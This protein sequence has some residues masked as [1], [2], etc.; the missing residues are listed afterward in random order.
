MLICQVAESNSEGT[1]GSNYENVANSSSSEYKIANDM[2]EIM[3][4]NQFDIHGDYPH[5]DLVI[6]YKNI[7][8]NTPNFENNVLRQKS[9]QRVETVV[10]NDDLDTDDSEISEIN[11]A[12]DL[13]NVFMANKERIDLLNNTALDTRLCHKHSDIEIQ[14]S[15]VSPTDRQFAFRDPFIK[16]QLKNFSLNCEATESSILPATLLDYICCKRLEDN[17]NFYMDNIIRYVQHTIEQ[18]KRI[19]N[20]DYLTDRAKEKWRNVDDTSKNDENN[21]MKVLATSTSIPLRVERKACGSMSSWDD[22]VHSEVDVR[23]LSKILEKKIVVEIPKIICGS[24][25]IISKTCANN[26]FISCN[27]QSQFLEEEDSRVDV[28]LK[29]ERS[30]SGQV[31]SNINSI[32]LLQIPKFPETL[33]LTYNK[34]DTLEYKSHH[35][36]PKVVEVDQVLNTDCENIENSR[37]TIESSDIENEDLSNDTRYSK[38]TNDMSDS[39]SI[40]SSVTQSISDVSYNKPST[41]TKSS[42]S[43]LIPKELMISMRN[44]D[45]QSLAE[46][47]GEEFP[48]DFNSTNI[49]KKRSP[50]RVRIKSPYENKSYVLEE[51]KRKRLLEI[52]EKREKRKMAMGEGCKV[53][54]HKYSKGAIMPQPSN[55]VTKLSITNKSFYNSIYGHAVVLENNQQKGKNLKSSPNNSISNI[56]LGRLGEE[57]EIALLSSERNT[58]KY[59]NR[60]FYLDDTETEMMYADTKAKNGDENETNSTYNTIAL[61]NFVTNFNVLSETNLSCSSIPNV[62]E[63]SDS[64]YKSKI[65]QNKDSLI[66]PRNNI[67][68]KDIQIKNDEVNAVPTNSPNSVHGCVADRKKSSPTLECRR[69]IDKIYDLIPKLSKETSEKKIDVLLRNGKSESSTFQ[70]SDS[71]TSLKHQI[72][73]SNPSSYSL[74]K[75][76]IEMEIKSHKNSE[77]IIP[78]VVINSKSQLPKYEGEKCKKNKK[79]VIN[80]VST[81]TDNPL[82]AISQ[83]LHEIENIQITNKDKTETKMKKQ[84]LANLNVKNNVRQTALKGRSRIDQP[85]KVSP[86]QNSTDKVVKVQTPASASRRPK[87]LTELSKNQPQAL[88]MDKGKIENSAKKKLVDIIDEAKEARG[89]AVRGPPKFNSRLNTLAQPKKSYI[90][91]HNEEYNTKYGRNITGDR[92]HRLAATPNGTKER[93]HSA[94]LKNKP[95]CANIE[96]TL[97]VA[98]KAPSVPPL[99]Q[100]VRARRSTSCSPENIALRQNTHHNTQAFHIVT[101]NKT[102]KKMGDVESYIHTHFRNYTRKSATKPMIAEQR[103]RVP[104]VPKDIDLD[105]LTSMN[106]LEESSKLGSKLHHLIDGMLHNSPPALSV[107]S[108]GLETSFMSKSD[109]ISYNE[110][111]AMVDEKTSLGSDYPIGVLEDTN[112]VTAVEKVEKKD[113]AEAFYTVEPINSG[114]QVDLLEKEL[115]K[116]ISSGTFKKNLRL[117]KLTLSPKQSL[118]QMIV[119]QSGDDGSLGAESLLSQSLKMKSTDK[120]IDLKLKPVLSKLQIDWDCLRFPMKITTIGYALPI[121]NHQQ[122]CSELKQSKFIKGCREAKID[123]IV[124]FDSRQLS[125]VQGAN[126]QNLKHHCDSLSKLTENNTL[127]D[128][129]NLHCHDR[130]KETLPVSSEEIEDLSKRDKEQMKNYIDKNITC[131]AV[132]PSSSVIPLNTLT[133]NKLSD[134]NNDTEK[135][136]K[137]SPER[138]IREGASTETGIVDNTSSLDILVNLLNEI[139]KISEC[140]THMTKDNREHES[141]ESVKKTD[142]SNQ[143]GCDKYFGKQSALTRFVHPRDVKSQPS[144]YTFY[145]NTV[146]QLKSESKGHSELL[147]ENAMMEFDPMIKMKR[148]ILVTFYSILAIT[149]FAALS[150]PEVLNV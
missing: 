16:E 20:G 38:N 140:Q 35:D 149:V 8:V 82:K 80:P 139:Q 55:S 86:Q 1:K 41:S 110:N 147:T 119:L 120:S 131:H 124:R 46:E 143:Q 135:A 81:V 145:L 39:T 99:G 76:E 36:A 105:S 14:S 29:L 52:R 10:H 4:R 53:N 107:L 67:P 44:L 45:I 61:T 78:R 3:M 91:A 126:H 132:Q 137:T 108:E 58:K 50:T 122:F 24:F 84:E 59:I 2:Y 103:S 26:L 22:I 7:D 60:S 18:L 72:T 142:I 25:K 62:A 150:L 5:R 93:I 33:A 57:Q 48:S 141:K 134:G 21:N 74:P 65:N 69:S 117:K 116:Q 66:A 101:G 95:R 17:Y 133:I 144:I 94:N 54:K 106:S 121:F 130:D 125:I 89:E 9:N 111:K 96:G 40:Y 90:Q 63:K 115:Y 49:N 112:I 15:L 56:P 97:S 113:I 13:H 118:K 83:L 23:S 85:I 79:V 123:S 98:A 75:N 37:E 148:D 71:G 30:K 102:T 6:L 42:H 138:E 87:P 109:V 129:V 68:V 51:K 47:T 27:K 43:F 88:A 146:R 70:E 128:A 136:T 114:T 19:S 100:T 12:E 28:V 34:K 73:S 104:L 127:M 11:S 31:I 77:A 64:S 92:L 32:M